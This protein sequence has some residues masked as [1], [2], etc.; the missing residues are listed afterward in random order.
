II[1]FAGTGTVRVDLNTTVNSVVIQSSAIVLIQA[2]RF[3]S[4][5]A[6]SAVN[7]GGTLLLNSSNFQG[8]GTLSVSGLVDIYGGTLDGPG[9]L[10][11]QS[12]G[13]LQFWGTVNS[14]RLL[15]DTTN[16]GTINFLDT[17]QSGMHFGFGGATLNN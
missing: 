1:P 5:S 17:I 3:L 15:R 12:G 4:V 9:S 16:S 14:S 13:L 2:G 6:P 8:A 11:I 10:T 7:A